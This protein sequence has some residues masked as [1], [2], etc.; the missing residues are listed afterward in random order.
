MCDK[1]STNMAR[2]MSGYFFKCWKISDCLRRDK[3]R[4]IYL[5]WKANM[6]SYIIYQMAPVPIILMTLK[7]T[8]AVWNPSECHNSKNIASISQSVYILIG[9]RTWRIILSIISKVKAFLR[10]QAIMSAVKMVISRKRCKIE[11]LLV[12]Q[13]RPLT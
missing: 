13:M 3:D 11:T 5:Q 7:V 12:L 9:K 2:S 10:S 1:L 4:D 8:V 6:K